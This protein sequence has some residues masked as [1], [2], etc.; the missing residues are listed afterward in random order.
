MNISIGEC[1]LQC[2]SQNFVHFQ[3]SRAESMLRREQEL[4]ASEDHQFVE[5]Y[6]DLRSNAQ[7]Y[8][9]DSTHAPMIGSRI[10]HAT[11]NI[12]PT[13][14]DSCC[15]CCCC[16][17]CCCP[18]QYISFVLY[19][20][21]TI[22]IF[23]SIDREVSLTFACAEYRCPLD[24]F[25]D[26]ASL[27]TPS[28]LTQLQTENSPDVEALNT[29]YTRC[30]DICQNDQLIACRCASPLELTV[31]CARRRT[32]PPTP[33]RRTLPT[34]PYTTFK[35]IADRGVGDDSDSGGG[36]L[37]PLLWVLIAVI[38]YICIMFVVYMIWKAVKR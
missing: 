14:N 38:V 27:L 3:P 12:E 11:V 5:I 26:I 8:C 2:V 25:R 30:L 34:P 7:Q 37:H 28:V 21:N 9:N 20:N 24:A 17:C 32:L 29:T 36:G 1:Q 4:S 31:G 13:C 6:R 18:T 19:P 10:S 33:T 15:F 16:C 22:P 23:Q 35:F